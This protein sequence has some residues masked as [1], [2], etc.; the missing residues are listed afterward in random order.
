[1]LP[2]ELR[3]TL[4]HAAPAEEPFDSQATQQCSQALLLYDVV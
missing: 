1:M 3:T 4:P 2:E